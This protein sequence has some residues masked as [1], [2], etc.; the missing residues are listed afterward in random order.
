MIRRKALRATAAVV[1]ASSLVLTGC[2]GSGDSGD[3]ANPDKSEP[4]LEWGSW[5]K[6]DAAATVFASSDNFAVLYDGVAQ[7]M[8]AFDGDGKELWSK[9]AAIPPTDAGITGP[10]SYIK[11]DTF[12]YQDP[13]TGKI[14]GLNTADGEEQWTFDPGSLGKCSAKAYWLLDDKLVTDSD[15]IVLALQGLGQDAQQI[16]ACS[17]ESPAVV[18]LQLPEGT[19]GAQEI[20]PHWQSPALP[21]GSQVSMPTVDPSGE[22]L[23]HVG[24]APDLSLIHI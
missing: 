8:R 24:S 14:H 5:Q 4:K 18:G 20:K 22:Y 12:I 9:P 13:Q 10:E 21:K 19:S 15:T 2:G 16:A 11:G 1:F 17:G 23:T 6:L 7:K 3:S